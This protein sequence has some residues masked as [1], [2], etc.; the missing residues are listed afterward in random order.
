MNEKNFLQELLNKIN[1]EIKEDSLNKLYGYMEY[2]LEENKKINLTAIKDKKDFILKHIIDSIIMLDK[3]ILEN[4]N[5]VIDIGTG[6]GFPGIPLKIVYPELKIT[7]VDSVEKKIKFVERACN[8]FN[9]DVKLIHERIENIGRNIEHREKYDIV[10]SKALASLQ[11]LSELSLPLLKVGK[12]MITSKGPKL[13]EEVEKSNNALKV[14]GGEITSIKE[15]I[16]PS[17][18][19]KRSIVTITKVSNTPMKYP[20]KAG[21]PN[22]KPL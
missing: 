18:D 21:I 10:V 19:I 15:M 22:K 5:N 8:K 11:I 16:I 17:T 20:R 14:L 1:I 7:L 4:G 13:S 2:L 6:G 9:I 3:S 12:V